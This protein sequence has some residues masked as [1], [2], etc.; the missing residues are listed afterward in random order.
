[1]PTLL[2]KYKTVIGNFEYLRFVSG[3]DFSSADILSEFVANRYGDGWYHAAWQYCH[4]SRVR[5][6]HN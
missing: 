1:M 6:L 3:R 4:W 2:I 5:P